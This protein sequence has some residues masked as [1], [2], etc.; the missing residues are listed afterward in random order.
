MPDRRSH[1][2]AAREARLADPACLRE[3]RS[4]LQTDH[5]SGLGR[6]RVLFAHSFYRM[7]GG[8][9]L[10]VRQQVDLAAGSHDV[11]L[12]S[13]AND[14]L[15][16]GLGTA[17]R[18]LYS[19]EKKRRVGAV[20][21]RFCPDVVHVHNSYPSLGPAVLLAA[22]ERG[23]PVVMTVHNFRL[24]CP[25]GI[26]FTDGEVCHRCEGG[27]Y[28]H[29]MMHRCF[30][31]KRQ[32]A[33]YASVLWSHRFVMPVVRRI[34]RFI[35]PSEFMHR[36][37][38]EWGLSADRVRLVRHFVRSR[39]TPEHGSRP[40]SYGAFLGRLSG[41]KGVGTLLRA[42]RRAGDPPFVIVGDGGLR[43]ELEAL[44]RD[45]ELVN[46]TFA[47]WRPHDE[48]GEVL[49]AARY[50]AIPSVGE[51]VAPLAALEALAAGRPL[52]VSDRGGLPELVAAGA[53]LLCR[54]ADERDLSE[55]IATL[56]R[57]DD[58]CRTASAAAAGT[59]R[60]LLSPQRH[61]ADLQ[62]VYSEVAQ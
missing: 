47:G 34:S 17:A 18:M 30:P 16:D 53:G 61:L 38:L 42:L 7:P 49:A 37:L 48:V 29:A 44:A 35:A 60:R 45:L 24:R 6:L 1:S 2:G 23:V 22:H 33:A 15:S 12:I 62:R 4:G 55:K 58:L 59:A 28:A 10:H 54:P 20:M 13:E 9:D 41:E 14:E 19:R 51:D 50:V 52:L 11:E 5:M 26:M 46:T 56:A 32:T 43:R 40:G 21:D 27:L 39:D 8:E 25:N 36:R 3:G 31:T 57:D